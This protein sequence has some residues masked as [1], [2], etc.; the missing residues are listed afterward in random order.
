MTLQNPNFIDDSEPN[1]N[2]NN[3]VPPLLRPAII[4]IHTFTGNIGISL[5]SKK[6]I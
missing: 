4:D 3:S 6:V 5:K 1:Q 2:K